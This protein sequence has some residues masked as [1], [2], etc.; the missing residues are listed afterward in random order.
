[1]PHG[2]SSP[3]PT[4]L[5]VKRR[6]VIDRAWLAYIEDGVEPEGLPAEIIRS[7]HRARESFGVDPTIRR[8]LRSLPVDELADRRRRDPVF[9]LAEPV[10]AEFAQRLGS[11]HHVLA[12]FDAAG[13]MLSLQGHPGVIEGVSDINFAPGACWAEESAGT[14][15]PGTAIREARPVEV[16]ASEHFVEAWQT[17]SC[18]GAPIF[19]P[20]ESVPVGLVDITGPWEIYSPHALVLAKAIA[21]N[22]E[23]RLAH[24]QSVRDEVIRFAF[25][26]GHGSSEILLAVDTEGR[27]LAANAAASARIG[28]PSGRIPTDLRQIVD[29]L[30]TAS[31]G[32][33]RVV[34]WRDVKLLSQP[35]LHDGCPV[36]SVLRALGPSG[37]TGRSR[38]APRRKAPVR[39]SFEQILSESGALEA[40]LEVARVASR[41]ALP[42]VLF[43]ESGTGKELF[44]QA[45]HGASARAAGPFVAVNCGSIPAPL[46]EAELFGYEAGAFTGGRK[47]G[48]AGKFEEASGGTLFLDEVSE[49][50]PQGQTALLRVLQEREIVRLGG[51]AP[52]KVDVRIVAA[53]NRD[54]RGEVAAR[55]FRQDLYY[56]LDV[57]SLSIPPLRQRVEDIPLLA[58]AFLEQA[59]AEVGRT[60]LRLSDEAVAALQGFDWPGNVRQLQNVVLRAAAMATGREILA[61]HLPAEISLGVPD[62]PREQVPAA[63]GPERQALLA[64]LER[65]GWNVA[66]AAEELGVSRMTLYRRMQR[67][68][69]ERPR[70]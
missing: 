12:Y 45:I 9:R 55:R 5:L 2:L 30:L 29:P 69:L 20:G 53:T 15:G 33:D 57:L 18:A 26:T 4:S 58:Q 63:D 44:A 32:A 56:R 7:W 62:A 40:V 37:A 10:L 14:N 31:P 60:G 68:G 52:R 38:P 25:R 23:A 3:Q 46:L 36:G 21:R 64:R 6:K 8:A 17:W 34:E 49:L 42:V 35:V 16:F 50:S 22:V 51:S 43:G 61:S 1:M 11:V 41:N 54:L 65:H 66:R 59:E 19:R 28:L 48:N 24:A 27:I 70:S 39:W 47:D 13:W 67:S